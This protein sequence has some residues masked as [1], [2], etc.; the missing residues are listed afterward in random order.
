MA[1]ARRP[2][3]TGPGR[4]DVAGEHRDLGGVRGHA[5]QLSHLGR[6]GRWLP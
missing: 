6:P 1:R 5:D 2:K 4:Q 3:A